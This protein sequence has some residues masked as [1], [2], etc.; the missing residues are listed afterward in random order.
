[1][2]NPHRLTLYSFIVLATAALGYNA[3]SI[4]HGEQGLIALTPGEM[5]QFFIAAIESGPANDRALPTR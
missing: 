1:M 5:D 3:I 2:T 4:L